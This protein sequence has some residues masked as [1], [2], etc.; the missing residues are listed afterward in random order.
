MLMSVVIVEDSKKMREE[1]SIYLEK[2][3][4]SCY[5]CGYFVATYRSCYI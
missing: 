2:C 3:G 1:L 5:L 4:Y